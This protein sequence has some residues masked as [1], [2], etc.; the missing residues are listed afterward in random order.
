MDL[1]IDHLIGPLHVGEVT[2]DKVEGVGDDARALIIYLIEHTHSVGLSSASLT[3][4]KV[5]AVVAIEYVHHKRQSGLLEDELLVRIPAK[6]AT[7]SKLAGW[8]LRRVV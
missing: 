5:R 6:G 1:P 7:K 2:E 4:N 3:V 8:L